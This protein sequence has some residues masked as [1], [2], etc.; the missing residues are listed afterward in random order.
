MDAQLLVRFLTQ[1][2]L[3]VIKSREMRPHVVAERLE[4]EPSAE[5]EVKLYDHDVKF[6]HVNFSTA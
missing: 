1:Q 4:F 5:N 6:L 2:K 3:K